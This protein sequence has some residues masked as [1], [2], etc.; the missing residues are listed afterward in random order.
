MKNFTYDDE[1]YHYGVKGM[2]WRRHK[3]ADDDSAKNSEGS[4]DKLSPNGT[5]NESVGFRTMNYHYKEIV[6][7]KP[8]KNKRKRSSYAKKFGLRKPQKHR[9]KGPGWSPYDEL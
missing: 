3:D 1:L 9:R 8:N 2:K 6:P 4:Y 5:R 7:R